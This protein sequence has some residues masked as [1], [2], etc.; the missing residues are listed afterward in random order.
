MHK[1]AE[2]LEVS[3]F[4]LL[5]GGQGKHEHFTSRPS[6]P[7]IQSALYCVSV[8]KGQ[9]TFLPLPPTKKEDLKSSLCYFLVYKEQV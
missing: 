3:D 8:I 5:L 2:G 4:W 9:A 1:L 7:Y 6:P